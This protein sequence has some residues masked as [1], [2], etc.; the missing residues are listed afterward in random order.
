LFIIINMG[1]VMRK[2]INKIKRLS[3]KLRLPVLYF[4]LIILAW[5]TAVFPFLRECSGGLGF[6]VPISAILVLLV[7]LPGFLVI[8][9][10]KII[11]PREFY[12]WTTHSENF[13]WVILI[14]YLTG[15]I[16]LFLIGLLIDVFK[17]KRFKVKS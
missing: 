14:Y 10:L 1:T 3:F 17:K 16:T 6:C 5:S 4:I 15:L 8:D 2:F 12:S 9:Q 13:L 11:L 7:G